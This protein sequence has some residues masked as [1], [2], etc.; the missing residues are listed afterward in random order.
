M[1]SI[2][3]TSETQHDYQRQAVETWTVKQNKS[4]YETNLAK[5]EVIGMVGMERGKDGYVK[6]AGLV[7]TINVSLKE[8]N[9]KITLTILNEF[10][11]NRSEN[12]GTTSLITCLDIYPSFKSK[13]YEISK[14]DNNRRF[15]YKTDVDD[16]NLNES[17]LERL[18]T[19]QG[20]VDWAEIEVK[21]SA[22]RTATSI[23]SFKKHQDNYLIILFY[24]EYVD[25]KKRYQTEND[26]FIL[27]QSS[28]TSQEVLQPI[29]KYT[30]SKNPV[31]FLQPT[32][33]EVDFGIKKGEKKKDI[34]FREKI[35]LGKGISLLLSSMILQEIVT[36][37]NHEDALLTTAVNNFRYTDSEKQWGATQ[38]SREITVD[39]YGS[40]TELKVLL[41]IPENNLVF[42]DKK[43]CI[44]PNLV[45]NFATY[46]TEE[47]INILK[48]QLKQERDKSLV[49]LLAII[50]S[51]D[52]NPE[53]IVPNI[54][55]RKIYFDS[56]G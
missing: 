33:I 15:F 51:G 38:E 13:Y 46:T 18:K 44:D 48:S 37:Q 22:E 11:L 1:S 50:E 30:T 25:P 29:G 6:K 24:N 53:D 40:V 49:E 28:D 36:L 31:I 4:T 9:D 32:K 47:G 14:R 35:E 12:C 45:S 16:E 52:L 5:I 42:I 17:L 54:K 20:L 3:S 10:N 43:I 26:D 41:T 2:A 27:E 56:V 55:S 34:F 23:K 8:S 19:R 39:K 7:T 21:S